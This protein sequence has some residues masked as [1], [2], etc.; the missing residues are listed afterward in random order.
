MFAYPKT[1][2][3]RAWRVVRLDSSVFRELSTDGGATV[4]A[5]VIV[6]LGA[7]ATTLGTFDELGGDIWRELP[8]AMFLAYVSWVAGAFLVYL[9]GVKLLRAPDSKADGAAVSRVMGYA[10]APVLVRVLGATPGVG[11]AVAVLTL[12]WQAA[13][14]LAGIKEV[15]ACKSYWKPVL[16]M[17]IGAAPYVA[18]LIGFNLLL[19]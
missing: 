6:L 17:A 16:I 8:R 5:L 13:A 10:N 12:I 2:A 11:V 3:V 19:S 14:T 18:V 9:I 4:Q 15:L 7:F 1:I